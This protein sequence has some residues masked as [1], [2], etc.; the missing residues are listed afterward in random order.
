M[1]DAARELD[2]LARELVQVAIKELD[3]CLQ[4]L[5]PTID[6]QPTRDRVLCVLIP[7]DY[8]SASGL[9]LQVGEKPN[10]RAMVLAVGEKVNEHVSDSG[11]KLRPCWH[12]YTLGSG[13]LYPEECHH[14]PFTCP[15]CQANKQLEDDLVYIPPLPHL[16]QRGDI[17]IVD[18]VTGH[19][20][21]HQGADSVD[22]DL[23][24]IQAGDVL[25][26]LGGGLGEVHDGDPT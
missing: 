22:I 6:L 14:S 1:T 24:L 5:D 11:S 2:K 25:A 8:V 20:V 23:R 21:P 12:A 13:E 10:Y 4:G 7:E 9:V 19:Q 26:V 18:A 15:N 17:I 3:Q 16:L